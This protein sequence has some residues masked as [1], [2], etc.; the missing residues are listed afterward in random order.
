MGW[1]RTRWAW[2]GRG[3][4]VRRRAAATAWWRCCDGVDVVE[5]P[6][7]R[8]CDGVDV[9]ELPWWRR[10]D[11]VDVVEL[12]WWR[13]CDGVD[14][15]E[16]PWWRCCARTGTTWTA[17]SGRCLR[18]RRDGDASGLASKRSYLVP[19]RWGTRLGVWSRPQQSASPREG[20]AGHRCCVPTAVL[21]CTPRLPKPY[22]AYCSRCA[23][24]SASCRV[25]RGLELCACLPLLLSQPPCVSGLALTKVNARP[26]FLGFGWR[27]WTP[28]V[29]S[30]SLLLRAA[31]ACRASPCS[32]VCRS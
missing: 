10:C 7:W 12:P 29:V 31:A 27:V 32:L 21:R 13:C 11:G 6:W 28:P 24:S 16:L 15:M 4:R 2:T 17:A 19:H 8:R 18:P 20:E 1:H 26:I 22:R 5:L 14:V 23:C 9:V 30:L 25:L 3:A